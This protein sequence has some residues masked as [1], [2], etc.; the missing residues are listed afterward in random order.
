[1]TAFVSCVMSISWGWLAILASGGL[2]G[3]DEV[4][5]RWPRLQR[6]MSIIPEKVRD[7]LELPIMVLTVFWVGFQS[8]SEQHS[9]L[10]QTQYSLTEA[11]SSRDHYL[12]EYKTLAVQYANMGSEV[13]QRRAEADQ[14]R[15]Y[16]D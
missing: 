15:S 7:R 5:K 4:A 8:W 9:Q 16:L 12:S 10:S 13:K 14:F 11:Q 2:F 3:V 6:W 1:M